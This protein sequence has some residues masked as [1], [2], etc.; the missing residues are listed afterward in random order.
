MNNFKSKLNDLT[1]EACETEGINQVL[2]S[3]IDTLT[4]M[5]VFSYIKTNMKGYKDFKEKVDDI[6]RALGDAC[7]DK[8]QTAL[9]EEL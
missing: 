6:T 5:I 2:F 8:Y 3:L 9:E 7:L 4:S 1:A